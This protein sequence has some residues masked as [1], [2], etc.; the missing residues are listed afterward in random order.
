MVP[1]TRRLEG[2]WLL[3]LFVLA[4]VVRLLNVWAYSGQEH[5]LV[6]G[7]GHTYVEIADVFSTTGKFGRIGVD[8][9]FTPETERVP[10][11][12]LFLAMVRSV[13]G[14]APIAVS[15]TQSL[16]DAGTVVMIAV[17]ASML[18]PQAGIVAGMLAAVWPN[19]VIHSALVLTDS[20]FLALLVLALLLTARFAQCPSLA[21]AAG[22]G[23]V[24][25][26]AMMTR[27]IAQFMPFIAAP[28]LV[29]ICLR[30]GMNTRRVALIALVFV[31]TSALPPSPLL[32]RNIVQHGEATLTTQGGNHLMHWVL[33]LVRQGI[34]GLTI[35][36]TTE[37]TNQEYESYLTAMG[38]SPDKIS[39]FKYNMMKGTFALERLSE[40]PKTAIA[41]AWLNG[42]ALNLCAPA[43]L[44]DPRI[45]A[46]YS[47]SFYATPGAGLGERAR[48]Y[49]S[50]A[51][52]IWLTFL[53]VG[54]VIV[55][56]GSAIQTWGFVNLWR[57]NLWIAILCVAFIVYFLG[58]M[59]P[60]GGPRYG[61]PFE[62]LLIIF[63][64]LGLTDLWGRLVLRTQGQ[65]CPQ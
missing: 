61:L 21:R 34:G 51:P 32:V 29:V 58:I 14:P 42:A 5:L 38:Y 23:L 55:V 60:V 27:A 1:S 65:E 41:S 18:V 53:G 45:R 13:A 54:F 48:S 24:L 56:L 39:S 11:Y 2:H 6:M 7:D 52:G 62:P 63:A 47:G 17:L 59:G 50:N 16:V 37:A 3:L 25:G 44:V 57:G 64:A 20:L 9:T 35:A 4:L 40:L 28:L 46:I 43:L 12:S 26:L 36:Q 8:G 30:R 19:M 22:I 33:P 31:V 15:I 10:I 49:L